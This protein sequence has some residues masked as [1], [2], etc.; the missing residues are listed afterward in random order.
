MSDVQPQ[1]IGKVIWILETDGSSKAVGGGAS[2]VL[3]F[4]EGLSIAQVTLK[5]SMK[6]CFSNYGWLNNFWSH[7]WNSNVIR[8]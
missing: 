5:P 1:D 8:S 3:Q 7:T 4:L 2:M 6:R